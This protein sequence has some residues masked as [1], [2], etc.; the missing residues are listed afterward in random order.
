MPTIN[1]AAIAEETGYPVHEVMSRGPTWCR[2]NPR[3]PRQ[4]DAFDQSLPADI[5]DRRLAARDHAA[6]AAIAGHDVDAVVARLGTARAAVVAGGAAFAI[7]VARM[8]VDDDKDL[9]RLVGKVGD[10]NALLTPP[11]TVEAAAALE[12]VMRA[13]TFAYAARHRGPAATEPEPTMVDVDIRVGR[14]PHGDGLRLVGQ[15]R[16]R[17]VLVSPVLS[18]EDADKAEPAFVCATIAYA[19]EI[20]AR[21]A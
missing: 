1:H 8:P 7:Y 16:G 21:A 2:R 9:L 5:D 11:L 3:L 4:D 20:D 10:R 6:E 17:T 14:R 15:H 19:T 13:A 12:P 18:V